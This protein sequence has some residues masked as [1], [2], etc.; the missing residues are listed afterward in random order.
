MIIILEALSTLR[1]VDDSSTVLHTQLVLA[2]L[3][4]GKF[5]SI[6]IIAIICLSHLLIQTLRSF[7]ASSSHKEGACA[8]NAPTIDMYACINY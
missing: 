1:V 5:L 4:S 3:A 7:I 6:I 8:S 2:V